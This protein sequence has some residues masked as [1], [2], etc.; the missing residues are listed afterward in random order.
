MTIGD[1]RKKGDA[2]GRGREGRRERRNTVSGAHSRGDSNRQ[3]ARVRESPQ[4]TFR[5]VCSA[6]SAEAGFASRKRATESILARF[7][8]GRESQSAGGVPSRD[9]DPSI[10]VDPRSRRRLGQPEEPRTCVETRFSELDEILIGFLDRLMS[11]AAGSTREEARSRSGYL[12]NWI[13][14]EVEA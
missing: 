1:R 7:G 6:R 10:P 5:V 3:S 13:S 9:P 11:L 8:G 14:G 12:V 4:T 2:R